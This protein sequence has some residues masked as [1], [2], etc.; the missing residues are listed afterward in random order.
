[1]AATVVTANRLLD[2]A[3]VYMA[4]GGRWSARLDAA[5]VDADGSGGDAMLALAE[6][7]VADGIVVGPYPIA[8]EADARGVRPRHIKEA[9][10]A[11]GPTV[12][13]GPGRPARG[14]PPPAP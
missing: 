6:R 9:I 13:F 10:R 5:L 2:G 14:R 7:A 8:V 11:H 4:P 12:R 1:M 3:V